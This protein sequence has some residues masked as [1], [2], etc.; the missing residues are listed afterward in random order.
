MDEKEFCFKIM[1]LVRPWEIKKIETDE[2]KKEVHVY[3]EYPSGMRGICPVCGATVKIH[4]KRE[5]RVWRHLDSCEY[6]TYIHCSVPRADCPEHGVKTMEIPWSYD[7]SKYTNAFERKVIDHY[8]ASKNRSKTAQFFGM[9]WDEVN[10]ITRRAVERGLAR[11]KEEE[12]QHLGIDEKSFLR[13]HKYAT[14]LTDSDRGRVLDVT[15]NRD[16]EGVVK[17]FDGFSYVQMRSV[18]SISMDFWEPFITCAGELLE[19]AEVVHDKFHIN[20][21]VN[22]AV[23]A[24]RRGEQKWRLKQKDSTLTGTKYL[25]LKKLENFT[26]KEKE[27]WTKLNLDQ[28]ETGKAWNLK[29]L[30]NEFWKCEDAETAEDFF[31]FWY[32]KATHSG[33]APVI[34]VAKTLKRHI[35]NILT[36]WTYFVSNSFAEGINS[37]IQEIKTVARGFRNFENY[38]TAILFFCGDLDL[39]P[40]ETQ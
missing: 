35:K 40:Q 5:E 20:K 32:F 22:G 36:Y 12:V 10:V 34:K 28:L 2:E 23:D 1:G 26:D 39:Y 24:V 14:I 4:D 31:N 25:W 11:R 18:R 16:T 8:K 7:L 13:H 30:F 29:E 9:S 33:L 21:Y 6:K 3:L 17:V 27:K 37:V 19:N 15:E 38:R